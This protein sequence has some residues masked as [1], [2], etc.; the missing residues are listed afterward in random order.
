M[1]FGN[2]EARYK[3]VK[4]QFLKQNFYIALSAFLDAGMV[5]QKYKIPEFA[6]D[7]PAIAGGFIDPDAKETPHIGYGGGVH[8]VLNQN[9][10]VAVD[11]GM[12]VKETDGNGGSMY[13][14]LNFLF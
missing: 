8:L 9:F 7:H 1:A 11:Y 3:V 13:I 6:M 5:T 12:A 14:G 10:I 2:I 4:T